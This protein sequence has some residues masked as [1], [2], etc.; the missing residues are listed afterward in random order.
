MKKVLII[1]SGGSGKSTAAIKLGAITGLPV[2]HLDTYF[3]KPDWIRVSKDEWLLKVKELCA[4]P[5]WIMDGNYR[6]TMD[7]RLREADTIIFLYFPRLI[8]IWG[9]IKRRFSK[10]ADTIEGC[11]EKIDLE[12][13][14][15]VWNYNGTH[16]PGIM[17]KL[18]NIKDKE[19][20]I[21]RN[22]KQLKMLLEDLKMHPYDL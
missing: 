7:L 14:K 11:R 16:V 1:G 21:L 19:I 22:R 4:Q 3:W 5:R 8:C 10:R 17:E 2:I 12:F 9:I 18:H 6:G 20:Y 15:W 13:F